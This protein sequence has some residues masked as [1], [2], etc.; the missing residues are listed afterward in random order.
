MQ[1]SFRWL[2]FPIRKSAD[3][4]IFADPRSLSQL[5]TSFFASE[6]QGIPRVPFLTFFYSC[7]F[8]AAWYVF[9]YLFKIW[10]L[11]FEYWDNFSA[12][13]LLIS[14]SSHLSLLLSSL[15]QF[16]SSNMSKNALLRRFEYW[17][18]RP[19]CV[20]V[21]YLTSHI[22]LALWR[23]TDSNRWPPACKAGALAS[24]ANPPDLMRWRV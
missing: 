15:F 3:Q 9:F 10:V 22:S 12:L 14:N 1:S 4:F 23:I 13:P 19:T 5:I 2:G 24:W 16:T 8:C 20:F 18:L 17:D 7:A 6:S 21:S 11:R